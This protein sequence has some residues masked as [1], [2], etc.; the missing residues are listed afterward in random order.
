MSETSDE[1]EADDTP[2]YQAMA[3]RIDALDA[4]CTELRA[5]ADAE[6]VPAVERNAKRIEAAVAI[7][8]Q[9]VPPELVADD[10]E[11]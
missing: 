11:D 1:R 2:D 10:R 5:L 8:R 6:D 7:L 3:E 9:H 4:E